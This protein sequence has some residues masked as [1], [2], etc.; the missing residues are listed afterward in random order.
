MTTSR[1]VDLDWH[2]ESWGLLPE[3]AVWRAR[4]GTLLVADVHF[5]KGDA[6][7]AAGIPVPGATTGADLTRLGEALDRTRADRLLVLGDLLHARDGRSDALHDA[8]A[9]W[10]AARRTLDITL[11]RGN[12]DHSAGDPPVSWGLACVDEP[13]CDDGIVLRHV[14]PDDANGPVLAGHVHPVTVVGDAAFRRRLACFHLS[15][16]V[17]TLP[18]FGSFT[19]GH[20][21]RPEAGDRIFAVGDG[22]VIEVTSLVGARR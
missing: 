8:F 19:G 11:V 14:P 13:W 1:G 18:A 10:R 12:H 16:G 22:D 2:G 20:R 15:G 17:M 5:G 9:A 6:F 21:V 4:T 3:R 7:R